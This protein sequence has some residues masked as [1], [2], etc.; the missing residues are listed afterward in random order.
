VGPEQRRRLRRHQRA[1]GHRGLGDAEQLR[2]PGPRHLP[3]RRAGQRRRQH[4]GVRREHHGPVRG[5]GSDPLRVRLAAA[6]RPPCPKARQRRG[7]G[8]PDGTRADL[9]SGLR[10]CG[11]AGRAAAFAGCRGPG[12]GE[13]RPGDRAG[14]GAGGPGPPGPVGRG[15]GPGA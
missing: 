11:L 6:R 14:E 13:R 1:R 12:A 10:G 15:D 3:D 2:H 9:A 7:A 8:R 4:G 5:C